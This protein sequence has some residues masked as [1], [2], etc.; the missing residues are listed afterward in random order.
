[1]GGLNRLL[2]KFPPLYFDKIRVLKAGKYI[3]CLLNNLA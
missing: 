3:V 1:M 2:I